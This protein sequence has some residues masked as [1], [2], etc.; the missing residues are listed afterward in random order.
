M[1]RL[2]E[3][4]THPPLPRAAF[5]TERAAADYLGIKFTQD[6]L[7]LDPPSRTQTINVCACLRVFTA[8]PKRKNRRWHMAHWVRHQKRCTAA[9]RAARAAR[10][11]TQD[12]AREMGDRRERQL[13][14]LMSGT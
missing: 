6:Y 10:R 11:L 9:K 4:F 14:G 2:P 12:V 7:V 1:M 5:S 3:T 8:F 13:L